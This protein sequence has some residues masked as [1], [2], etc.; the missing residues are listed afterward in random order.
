M[1][2]DRLDKVNE[3]KQMLYHYGP[4]VKC[5]IVSNKYGDDI[6]SLNYETNNLYI[7]LSNVYDLLKRYVGTDYVI[8]FENEYENEQEQKDTNKPE[9]DKEETKTNV[10]SGSCTNDNLNFNDLVKLVKANGEI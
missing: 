9:S 5:K 6:I 2:Q 4:H 8:L 3:L 10:E 1:K 7:N